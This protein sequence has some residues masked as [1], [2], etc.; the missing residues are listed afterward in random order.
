M[1]F[2]RRIIQS[3]LVAAT[4][5]VFAATAMAQVTTRL[6]VPGGAATSTKITPGSPVSFDVRV[7][8]TVAT[9]GAAYFIRNSAPGVAPFPFAITNRSLVGV[10]YDDVGSESPLA[11]I[12]A[13][14]AALLAPANTVNLGSTKLAGVAAGANILVGTITLSSDVASPLGVYTIRPDPGNAFMTDAAF[15]DYD[16]SGATFNVTIG[17]TLTVSVVGAGTVTASSGLINCP[18]VCSDIYPGTAVTLTPNPTAP[19]TF[20][21]WSGAC[22]GTGAC[23]V[24]VD[25]AKS[26]TAT[27]S[28]PQ[29]T[30]T[31]AI[32]GPGTGTVTGTGGVSCPGTCTSAPLNFGTVVTVTATGTG[33]STFN[34]WSG[35]T[36]SG[37]TNPC[38]FTVNAATANVQANFDISFPLT[39]NK[40]GVPGATGTVTSAPAGIN[41]GTACTTQ[42]A[43][44]AA[45]TVVT[46]TA[47]PDAGKT[48][49]GFSGGG[50]STSPCNVT[51]SAA[52]TVTATFGDVTA[53]TTTI[54]TMPSDPSSVANP[55]FTFSSNEPGSTFQCSLDGAPFANCSSPTSVLVGNGSHT[56]QVRATDPA[57]NV[58]A[59]AS[60]TWLAQGIVAAPTVIPTLSEWMLALLAL[61][62][63]T[64]GYL[65]MRRRSR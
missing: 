15:N 38:T 64:M 54:L 13:V 23:V 43:S 2:S 28:V 51:V 44:F 62:L 40:A 48:F 4:S 29:G 55:Q 10:P 9:I 47:T 60:F 57:G 53:P 45:G 17:Q 33:G 39:V 36:C 31:A 20:T 5:A 25:A 58:G 8:T 37:S 61:M 1:T 49:V 26:V 63:G 27:F 41:C 14:P 16:M 24:T 12:I 7:D 59:P 42:N 35:G 30:Y 50:C 3:L 6:T 21:G 19:A 46:L 56:F 18:G 22:S 32:G 34:S 65:A 52:T 11:T